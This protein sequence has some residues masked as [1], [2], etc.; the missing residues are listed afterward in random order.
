MSCGLRSRRVLTQFPALACLRRRHGRGGVLVALAPG[1]TPVSG[2]VGTLALIRRCR[3][4]WYAVVKLLCH[5]VPV[6]GC[7]PFVRGDGLNIGRLGGWCL[8][9]TRTVTEPLPNRGVDARKPPRPRRDGANGGM[10]PL[11][12]RSGGDAVQ[13]RQLAVCDLRGDRSA[14]VDVGVD[15]LDAHMRGDGDTSAP[16]IEV[17]V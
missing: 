8:P 14:A 12:G 17:V 1:S 2:G 10:M 16:L 11:L 4:F 7:G 13:H 5:S 15:L 3:W 6:P 9:R